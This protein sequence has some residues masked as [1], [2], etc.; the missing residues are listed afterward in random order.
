MC[1]RVSV[2]ECMCV[3]DCVSVSVCV[4]VCVCENESLSWKR[5]RK[6]VFT[7]CYNDVEKK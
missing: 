3:Y 6:C 1:G 7:Y 4:S 2:C 5:N